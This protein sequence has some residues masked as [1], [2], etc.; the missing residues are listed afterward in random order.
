VSINL[1]INSKYIT[2]LNALTILILSWFAYFGF[3]IFIHF[4]N[5]FNSCATMYTTFTSSL[6]YLN[7]V[8]I[9]GFTSFIDLFLHSW[10]FNFSDSVTNTLLLERKAK[11][12]LDN[13]TIFPNKLLKYIRIFKQINNE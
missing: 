9:V 8:L 5:I 13:I 7:F 11:V 12:L 1:I 6:V 3:I 2:I 10:N 4:S